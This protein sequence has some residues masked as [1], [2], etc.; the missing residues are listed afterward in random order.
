MSRSRRTTMGEHVMDWLFDQPIP[1][2]QVFPFQEPAG[3]V[4]AP[5]QT[6]TGMA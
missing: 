6:S 5:N 2:I 3:P 1:G 4:D